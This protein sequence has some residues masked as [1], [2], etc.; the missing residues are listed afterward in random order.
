MLETDAPEAS[1]VK[2]SGQIFQNH[3][4]QVGGKFGC[5]PLPAQEVLQC[6][7]DREFPKTR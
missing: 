1:Y 4:L 6:L 7:V 5:H 3:D 2:I